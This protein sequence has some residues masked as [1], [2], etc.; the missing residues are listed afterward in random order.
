MNLASNAPFT[1][2]NY[3]LVNNDYFQGQVD[4]LKIWKRG[5]S[6]SEIRTGMCKKADDSS[7]DLVAYLKFDE[8]SGNTVRDNSSFKIN[9]SF[10]NMN[11]ATAWVT[12]SAPIGD[13]SMSTYQIPNQNSSVD[14]RMQENGYSFHATDLNRTTQGYHIYYVEAKP[15][16]TSGIADPA[17]VNSYFGIFQVGDP[18]ANHAIQ[19]SS[20]NAL[21]RQSLYTRS[22]NAATR[23]GLLKTVP[24]TE[25]LRYDNMARQ[26]EFTY[27]T[28]G[29]APPR[30][31]SSGDFC[32]GGKATLQI[33]T[34]GDV[35]WST[36]EK[37]KTISVN[38]PGNYSVTVSQDGCSFTDQ[39]TIN[40]ISLPNVNLGPDRTLCAGEQAVL[41]AP[42]GA[43][44]Y[45]W[46]TG[47]TGSSLEV[48]TSGKYWVEVTNSIGCTTR[49]EVTVEV[50][51][52]PEFTLPQELTACYGEQIS[53]DAMT[54]GATY[55]WSTGH[56]TPTVVVTAPTSLTVVITVDGCTYTREVN[57]VSNEC[58]IIPNIITPNG[59]GKNDT[60]VLQGINIDQVEIEI[61][62]RWG[63][64]VFK[65]SKYD[66]RWSGSGGGMYYYHIKSGQTQKVYKG[67]VEVVR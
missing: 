62:N 10:R 47:A 45:K 34:T 66:N 35:L 26:A 12:S 46:S 18:K 31:Q 16:T 55:L 63:A 33:N 14:L 15:N 25:P 1:V 28:T 6:E 2:G 50:R 11:P 29:I 8:G 21:C 22:D 36:G 53:V 65:S 60:F 42:A 23:W 52:E 40:E 49:D 51:T 43:Y 39:V 61:F 19:F 17:Q 48:R 20:Q 58:P 41:S 44:T 3:Y 4:E 24:T 7:S 37:T 13:K 56:T 67:W 9:G 30:I 27:N 57:V 5:L 64:S 59:D 38:Q 32:Q 54:P